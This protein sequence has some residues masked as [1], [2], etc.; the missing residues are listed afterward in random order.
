MRLGWS[1]VLIK[2][3]RIPNSVWDLFWLESAEQQCPIWVLFQSWMIVWICINLYGVM[4]FVSS[5][6]TGVFFFQSSKTGGV[7]MM[8]PNTLYQFYL[9]SPSIWMSFLALC[10]VSGSSQ[11][12][13]RSHSKLGEVSF[14]GQKEG[15]VE[16]DSN[17][18]LEWRVQKN[19]LARCFLTLTEVG[20]VCWRGRR[21]KQIEQDGKAQC[22]HGEV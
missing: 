16:G 13:E 4:V 9:S 17:W 21:R 2:R 15:N 20:E 8:H 11:A 1:S 3:L 6:I 5:L 18:L 22:P 12:F 19:S 7:C 14:P 10:D